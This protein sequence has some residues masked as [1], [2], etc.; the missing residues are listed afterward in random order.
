MIEAELSRRSFASMAGLGLLALLGAPCAGHAEGAAVEAELRRLFSGKPMATG[1]VRLVL[2]P[3]AENGLMVA[4][5]VEV[6]S[7]M[8]Q[9][10]Y[11]R[12]VHVFADANPSPHVLSWHFTPASGRAAATGRIRLARTQNV[13]AV[14]ETSGGAL[15]IARTQ[16]VVTVGGC[17]E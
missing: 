15:H 17:G 16:V 1:L 4:M 2:P 11:V 12:S 6:E 9:D 14:A 10:D 7:P 13:T 5:S 8:T 3:V